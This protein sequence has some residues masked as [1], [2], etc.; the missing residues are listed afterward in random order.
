MARFRAGEGTERRIA[1]L[2][3]SLGVGS[4]AYLDPEAISGYHAKRTWNSSK[5]YHYSW[6]KQDIQSSSALL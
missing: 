6:T 5:V 3:A 1:K 4:K 2:W